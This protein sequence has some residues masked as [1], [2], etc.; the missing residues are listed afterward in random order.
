MYETIYTELFKAY[1]ECVINQTGS[2]LAIGFLSIISIVSILISGVLYE[3]YN[4]MKAYI[5]AKSYNDYIKWKK[6]K[7]IR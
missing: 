3:K 6:D 1:N 4:I 2:T 7:V 5:E